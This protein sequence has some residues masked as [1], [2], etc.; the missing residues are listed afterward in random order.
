M[1]IFKAGLDENNIATTSGEVTIFNYNAITR[2]YLNSNIEFLAVGVGIPAHSCVDN[3]L[4]NKPG[5]VVCRNKK[6]TGWEY[7][8]DYRGKTAYH[9]K[10]RQEFNITEIGELPDILTFEKPNTE[11]DNWDGTKWVTDKITLKENQISESKKQQII[12][13]KKANDAI[14][15]LQYAIDTELATDKERF[16][17][18]KWKKYLV[19][20]N[21]VD[22]SVSPDIEWPK[23]PE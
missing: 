18:I 9:I 13:R 7:L 16:S 10:T 21:R 2:E 3:P 11:F 8:S 1:I 6:L 17:L 19:L 4:K 14:L 22:F 23:L 12:L 5:F 15:P 20:L